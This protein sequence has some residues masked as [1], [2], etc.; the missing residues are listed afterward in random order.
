MSNILSKLE[1]INEDCHGEVIEKCP[2]A[3]AKDSEALRVAASDASVAADNT[4]FT[5]CLSF[6]NTQVRCFSFLAR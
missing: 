2:L 6:I 4:K 5:L 1:Y 3:E